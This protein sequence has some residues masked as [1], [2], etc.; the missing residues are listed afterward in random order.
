MKQFF[1][2]KTPVFAGEDVLPFLKE[3]LNSYQRIFLLADFRTMRKCLHVVESLINETVECHTLVI[4]EGERFKNINT[5]LLLWKQLQQLNA[6]RNDLIVNIGGGVVCDIGAFVA[7]TFKRGMQFIQIPTSLMAMADA[8]IG[9]KS[10][11]D[12]EMVKNQIGMFSEPEAIYIYPGF[13]ETLDPRQVLNGSTE[14]IKHALIKDAELWKKIKSLKDVPSSEEF[15]LK[16][17]E[18]KSHVINSDFKESGM[19]RILNFGH[20]FGHAFESYSLQHDSHPLLHGEALAMGIICESWL[21]MHINGFPSEAFEEI[22]N[23]IFRFYPKY[24]LPSSSLPEL[25]GLMKQDKK[26]ID[27]RINVSLLS[28][29]GACDFDNYCSEDDLITALNVYYDLKSR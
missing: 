9:G 6:H 11:V 8:A 19:R 16:S 14:I 28:Q 7:S 12:L 17:A 1:S 24:N 10:G 22:R 27:E 2:H 4:Q 29:T 15:I 20:T 23:Y 5:C 3:K 26:N 13:L 21:S 18:I 25:V